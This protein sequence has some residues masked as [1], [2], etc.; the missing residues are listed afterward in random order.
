MDSQRQSD[1]SQE[2]PFNENQEANFPQKENFEA[3]QKEFRQGELASN[4]EENLQRETPK[5]KLEDKDKLTLAEEFDALEQGF[6]YATDFLAGSFDTIVNLVRSNDKDSKEHE[7]K[8]SNN[9]HL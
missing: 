4:K 7:S 9:F 8:K 6:H 2:T 3:S 5:T 1:P